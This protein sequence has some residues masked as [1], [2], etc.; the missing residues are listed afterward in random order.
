MTP[1]DAFLGAATR[2]GVDVVEL[3]DLDNLQAAITLWAQVWQADDPAEIMTMSTLRALAHAGNYVAGAYRDGQ[4][5]G[6][7]L[8]FFGAGHLH[9][10]LT[11]ITSGTRGKGVGHV[12]KLHQRAWALRRGIPEIH[13][14]F[15]PLVRRNAYFNFQ[16]LGADAPAYL[17]DFYGPLNDGLNRGDPSDRLYVVW[18][19]AGER[20]EAAVRGELAPPTGGRLIATPE[21]IESLRRTDPDGAIQ[22]RHQLRRNL[23]GCLSAGC[24]ILGVTRDGHYVLT[25]ERATTG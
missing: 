23:H 9:S 24:R 22:W 15:D 16:K 20:A 17:V 2:A 19:L 10:H 3:A 25:P 14:T 1:D 11:G 18:D 21:D 7:S 12:L 5:V 8:G 13:W 6:A 4:L